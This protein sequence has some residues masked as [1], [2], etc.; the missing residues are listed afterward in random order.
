MSRQRPAQARTIAVALLC[1]PLALLLLWW[2]CFS[3]THRP[4]VDAQSMGR[5]L[6]AAAA[7]A[8]EHCTGV[9]MPLAGPG[10]I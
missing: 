3:S 8:V 2:V 4:A 1:T 5:Q 7:V 6:G 9:R 10:G